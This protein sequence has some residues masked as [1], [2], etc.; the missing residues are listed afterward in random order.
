MPEH[1]EQTQLIIV[2][3]P[4]GAGKSTLARPLARRL[5]LPLI[6]K[7][8]IKERLADAFGTGALN[9]ADRFGLAAILQVYAIA[10]ELVR[11][12]QSVVIESFFHHGKAEPELA[13]LLKRAN[14]LQ[15]YVYADQPLLISRYERRVADPERHLIH[16][17]ADRLDDLLR[18]LADGTTAPLDLN[19]PMLP[20][21]TTYG[22]VDPEE[23]AFI[24]RDMLTPD[25]E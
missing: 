4:P 24:I 14:A 21:D 20:I 18:Y 11:A 17:D 1:H 16:R 25:D 6:A 8:P 13:P 22:P 23:V 10:E 9:Y 3:G 7:D 19:I 12:G 2:N 15:V 5:G